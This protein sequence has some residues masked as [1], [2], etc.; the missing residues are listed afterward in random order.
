MRGIA[1][2]VAVL[3]L[4]GVIASVIFV[5]QSKPAQTIFN[6]INNYTGNFTYNTVN[7]YTGE[8]ITGS[9]ILNR[10][11]VY[12]NTTHIIASDIT[13]DGSLVSIDNVFFANL[14]SGRIGIGTANPGL[15]FEISSRQPYV[16]FVENDEQNYTWDY[17]MFQ[18]RLQYIDRTNANNTVLSLEN[19]TENIGIRT[20]SPTARLHVNGASPI[21]NISLNVNNTLY[22]NGSSNNIGIGIV[23]PTAKLHLVGYDLLS[24]LSLNI[25]GLIYMNGLKNTVGIGTYIPNESL[26][27]GNGNFE[28]YDTGTL[29]N[30]FIING[31]GDGLMPG[32][33]VVNSVVSVS[34]GM[35]VVTETSESITSM[36]YR[37]VVGSSMNVSIGKR[38]RYQAT[39][40]G[41]LSINLSTCNLRV[42]TSLGGN[43]L[44]LISVVSLTATNTIT[45]DFVANTSIVYLSLF[46]TS[47][48]SALGV[49]VFDNVT[50]KEVIGGNIYSRGN[51]GIG[52]STPAYPLDVQ[53]NTS[54]IS[55]YAQANVSAKG[56]ITRT[57]VY[58]NKYGSALRQ[59]KNA[60][61]YI[62][63]GIINHAKFGYSFVQVPVIKDGVEQLEDGISLD[64]E[65][66][67]LKQAV[68]ELN[69]R[70][71]CLKVAV[72]VGDK[73]L[74]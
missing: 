40:I 23:N 61:Y 53:K 22:V 38:Y 3:I 28:V 30:D 25:S 6:T 21:N 39:Y 60:S 69:N 55:I 14:S 70:V 46:G 45:I 31:S 12:Y 51:V 59:I 29:G 7:N 74:C 1:S 71:E 26:V 44:G 57:E 42:G 2:I 11:A 35:F 56:Y 49:M 20:S 47:S 72:T 63:N 19:Q 15:V 8:N 36:A 41:D 43:D 37:T 33:T 9:G 24:N 4:V 32:W 64:K 13:D 68:Y 54:G 10:I 17:G 66:A 27:V 67:L 34:T 73:N 48:G 16:R 50:F 18:G 5:A 62:D 65:V 52:T 58:D